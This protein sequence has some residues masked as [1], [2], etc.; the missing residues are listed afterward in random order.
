MPVPATQAIPDEEEQ[1]V[2]L[3]RSITPPAIDTRIKDQDKFLSDISAKVQWAIAG[4]ATW[5]ANLLKW[6]KHYMGIVG[7]KTFPWEECSNFFVPQT[8]TYIDTMLARVINPLF[9]QTPIA[10]ARGVS[11]PGP[12]ATG[13]PDHQKDQSDNPGSSD[14]QTG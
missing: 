5:Q 2:E 14:R 12:G 10:I 13:K 4:R 8:A 9:A 3:P 11:A 1:G 6:H 7:E